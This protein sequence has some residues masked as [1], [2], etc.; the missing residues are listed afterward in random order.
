[1]SV[2]DI[3]LPTWNNPQ[4]LYPCLNSI[5]KH[6]GPEDLYHIYV[7][8]NGTPESVEPLKQFPNCTVLQ[9][10]RNLGWEGGL[11]AGLAASSAPYV[12]FMN[13]DTFVPWNQRFWLSRMVNYLADPA[14][15]AVGPS[16]N[17]VMGKQNLFLPIYESHIRTKFLIGFCMMLK[18]ETL[19][20][21]GGV[22]D[23]LPGGDDLDLSIR[24]RK[25][26]KYLV[27]DREILIYHHGFKTGERILGG[28]EK[29]GGW[30]SL[31]QLEKTNFGLINKHGLRAFL[32]LWSDASSPSTMIPS[33]WG[34]NENELVKTW[35][36]GEKVAELGCGD[37]KLFEHSVG[38]DIVPLGTEIAGLSKG[39]FSL[40]DVTAN[41][42]EELPI[43]GF[44]TIIAQ[45]VLEHTVDAVGAINSW[46]KALRHGGRLII[47]VPDQTYRNTIPLNWEHRHAWTP[48][49]LKKFMEMLGMKTIDLLDPKNN[50][51]FIGIFETNGE[52]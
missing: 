2:I 20:A 16:S 10:E 19:E 37:K 36:I 11:K 32:D 26:G 39:R 4:Y 31:E 38:I 17:V 15:G 33:N 14:C 29:V 12:V 34:D 22:D 47:A 25:A 5:A 18:R 35:T 44:D 48:K 23:S 46:K 45:H 28:P 52:H 30:N 8:N 50:V 43:M 51:S 7:V 9:Q 13:D 42:E 24:L 40:A 6:T 3:L 27:A 21:V 49:S 1:M 41:I